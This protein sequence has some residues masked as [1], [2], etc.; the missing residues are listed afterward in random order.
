MEGRAQPALQIHLVPNTVLPLQRPQSLL[1]APGWSLVE[2]PCFVALNRS[3][4]LQ[5]PSGAADWGTGGSWARALPGGL[6]V[7]AAEGNT[8][9]GAVGTLRFL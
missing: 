8:G 9:G 3:Q 7:T 1:L 6:H 2:T 5:R 4:L